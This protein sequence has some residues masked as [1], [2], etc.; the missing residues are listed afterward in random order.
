[1]NLIERMTI[2][3]SGDVLTGDDLPEDFGALDSVNGN[4]AENEIT[5]HMT[6][7]E[8]EEMLVVN[9]LNRF[10]WN[11]TKAAKYLNIPRHVLIYRM[12]K[13]SITEAARE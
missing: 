11:R 12:K 7:Q 1:E 13:Y 2:L 5:N 10:G 4:V 6:Y 9:A 8:A 3:R